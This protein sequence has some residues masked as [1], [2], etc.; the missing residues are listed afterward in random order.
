MATDYKAVEWAVMK[1]L[2]TRVPVSTVFT[3]HVASLDERSGI[4]LVTKDGSVRGLLH[5]YVWHD[6]DDGIHV[7]DAPCAHTQHDPPG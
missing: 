3:V 5:V 7:R 6:E 1:H 2:A 4:A